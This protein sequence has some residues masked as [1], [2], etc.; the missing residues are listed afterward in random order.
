MAI[1]EKV[2]HASIVAGRVDVWPV[3]YIEFLLDSVL[4]FGSLFSNSAA[5]L[6]S[7]E[8]LSVKS[9]A[10]RFLKYQSLSLGS[11]TVKGST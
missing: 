11:V 8:V 4:P 9:M 10:F 6:L 3:G 2:I 7:T 5:I 1:N